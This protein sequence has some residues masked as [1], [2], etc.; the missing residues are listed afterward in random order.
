LTKKSTVVIA[1]HSLPKFCIRHTDTCT[2]KLD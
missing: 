2:V 1:L